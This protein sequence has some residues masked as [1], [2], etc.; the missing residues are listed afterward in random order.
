MSFLLRAGR[1]AVLVSLALAAAVTVL[2]PATAAE[3]LTVFAAASLKTA[4]DDVAPVFTAAT[5][6]PVRFSYAA[7]P[8]LARQIEN[9][10]PADVF[11]S[12]DPEWMDYLQQ[13]GLVKPETR[14]SLLG[15]R[16]V[17]IAP[18]DAALHDLPLTA[19]AIRYAIGAT[20]RIATGE[21]ASVPAGRYAK[22]ALQ[23][24]GLWALAEPRL[25]QSENVRAALSFVARGEAPLGIVYATDASSEPKVK[26]VARFPDGSHPPIV[27]PFAVTAGSG[28][29]EAARQFIAALASARARAIFEA[30][31][32]TVLATPA[33]TN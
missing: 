20:G 18:A 32:F 21:V 4:L 30:Q 1:R 19:S 33:S 9:G 5:G 29:A 3:P 10:A 17:V 8:A 15:N 28:R 14:L 24:L 31:G 7:S 12:A 23:T 2:R 11:A 27:Y 26:V 6:I 16:L 25:A 13:R 22:A